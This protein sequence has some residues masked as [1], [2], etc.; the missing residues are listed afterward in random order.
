MDQRLSLASLSHQLRG[1]RT[2]NEGLFEPVAG[3]FGELQLRR[4]CCHGPRISEHALVAAV[5]RDRGPARDRDPTSEDVAW[6]CAAE[7]SSGH[8]SRG[9]ASPSSCPSDLVMRRSGV[10]SPEAAPKETP[11]DLGGAKRRLPE[12]APKEMPG[13][14]EFSRY[15]PP[16]LNW[17]VGVPFWRSPSNVGFRS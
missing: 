10:Q 6:T 15:S 3:F 2:Q 12:A 16:K 17:T 5:S 7:C 11:N 8:D 4:T 13:S 14:S 9:S 1:K